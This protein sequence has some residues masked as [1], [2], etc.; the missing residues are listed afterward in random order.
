MILSP[1]LISF[2][3]I[4]SW[5]CKVAFETTTPPT[6][7]GSTFATGVIAPVLP[8]CMFISLIMEKAFSEE[9]LYA[10][11]HLGELE[12][13]P[14]LLQIQIVYFVNYSINIII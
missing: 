13:L 11:A 7:T 8:T 6:V 5:L 3:S 10:V 1:I 4:S 9:N 14:N 2:L 12:V